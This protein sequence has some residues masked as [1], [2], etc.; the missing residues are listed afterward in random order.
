[1][2]RRINDFRMTTK[3]QISRKAID[4]DHVAASPFRATV[5]GLSLLLVVALALQAGVGARVVNAPCNDAR[6]AQARVVEIAPALIRQD[7]QP[8][9][10]DTSSHAPG[11]RG[12]QA[13]AIASALG[14]PQHGESTGTEAVM[15]WRD[16]QIERE[17]NLPPP[18]VG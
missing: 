12:P 15:D 11:I 5:G 1:M 2:N 3:T 14:L 17:A 6:A 16:G 4:R 7:Q 18:M 9:P 8:D 13:C 10:T